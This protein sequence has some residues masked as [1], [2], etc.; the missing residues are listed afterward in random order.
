MKKE[1]EMYNKSNTLCVRLSGKELEK[2]EFI[3]MNL[4]I[5]DHSKVIRELIK[6]EFNKIITNM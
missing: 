2:L 1:K 3:R 5:R 4:G 6:S